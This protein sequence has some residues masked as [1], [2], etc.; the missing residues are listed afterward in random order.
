MGQRMDKLK[1]GKMKR[2]SRFHIAL[3]VSQR[4]G[5]RIFY[6]YIYCGLAAIVYKHK[7]WEQANTYLTRF[8]QEMDVVR[9]S[10]LGRPFEMRFDL[11]MKIL[12]AD[13]LLGLR[14]FKEAAKVYS[15][16]PE[17]VDSL[18]EKEMCPEYVCTWG[19]IS[20]FHLSLILFSSL[21]QMRTRR[22]E[23]PLTYNPSPNGAHVYIWLGPKTIDQRA[24]L[25]I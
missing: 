19:S 4:S 20:V 5:I 11:E 8:E 25:V 1:F 22:Q 21:S 2:R 10:H 6:G 7:D 17:D 18:K 23:T 24:K 12:K 3:K 16:I 9:L 13:A 14:R 15:F